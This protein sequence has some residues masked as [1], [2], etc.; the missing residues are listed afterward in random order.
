MTTL[1]TVTGELAD[2][3]GRILFHEHIRLGFSGASLDPRIRLDD[4]ALVESAAQELRALRDSH[5]VRLI[6]DATPA[7]F[8]RD[9]GILRR[10]AESS[11]VHIIGSTGMYRLGAGYPAYWQIQGVED[12]EEYFEAE[13]D[14]DP[15]C[16]IIKVG[17]TGAYPLP[18]EI[19]T[20]TA[21]AH[22]A[23][24]TG[25]RVLTHTDPDGWE[26]GNPGLAQM[27]ILTE[28]GL[29]PDRVVVGHACGARQVD[30]LLALATS[31]CYIGFDRI[32][33][34]NVA[35]DEDRAQMIM[36]V[37]G[38]GHGDRLL[39]SHDHQHH[40]VRL[41]PHPGAPVL[42]R[43]FALLFERFLPV[44]TSIGVTADEIEDLVSANPRNFLLGT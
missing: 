29:R 24:R 1:S 9:L 31:G 13:L 18:P 38:A 14:G 41:R 25:A 44:L 43:S 12:L 5:G 20:L 16:G 7:D 19:R 40:W 4:H 22:V 11:G 6:V 30:Q 36:A 3:D 34:T 8:G 32:G 10:V 39:L 2:I 33:M 27:E 37:I 28:E 23:S 15:A 26:H 17:T 35:A 42:D 21:A